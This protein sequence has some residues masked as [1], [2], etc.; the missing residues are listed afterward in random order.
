MKTLLRIGLLISI[1]ALSV[2]AFKTIF[3]V[4]EDRD[5]AIFSLMTQAL[6]KAHYQAPV[7]DDDFSAKVM[8]EYID[9]LDYSKRFLLQSDIDMLN[10]YRYLIDD[11]IR[12][13]D[14]QV[15]KMG[16]SIIKKRQKEAE[17]YFN[18][19]ISAGF[20]FSVDESVD[21]NPDS[22]S[23]AASEA[24]LKERWRK[25]T[26]LAVLERLYDMMKIQEKAI[27]DNDTSFKQKTYDEMLETATSRVRENY[28]E[29]LKRINSIKDDDWTAMFFNA[30]VAVCDPHSEYMPPED[31]ESFDIAMSG[32]FEGIGATLQSRNGQTKVADIIPGS[33]SWR[34][35]ELEVGDI[36][37]MVGQGDDEPVDIGN[38]ALSDAVKLIRGKK[39]STVKLTVKKVDNTVKVIPIVRDVVIIE[40][41]YAKSSMLTSAN[42]DSK[43]G[44]IYLPKFYADF[45]DR[46]GR[47]CSKDVKTEVEK[48]KADGVSG[49]I[50]D[51]RNNG[52]GSLGD[53]VE[54]SGL[55]VGKSPAV[56]VRKNTGE[57]SSHLPKDMKKIYDGP[58]VVM[59]NNYSASASE[60]LAAALQDHDR[61]IIMGSQST[62]GKGTVQAIYDFDNLIMG[63][64]GIK[65]LGAIKLTIQKFYRINGGT[66]Q[67]QGVIPDIVVPDSYQYMELG[68]KEMHNALPFDNIAKAQYSVCKNSYN[69]RK[70]VAASQ[71]RIKAN[72]VFEQIDQNAKRLK[73][74]NDESLVTL[75][76][77][78]YRQRQELLEKESEQYNKIG[79]D[80]TGVK[81]GFVSSDRTAAQ[82]DTIKTKKFTKWFDEL[83]KD[84]YIMEATNVI[85]DMVK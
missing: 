2:M 59:V 48:L 75:N 73:R 19:V 57:I 11:H 46:Q 29:W 80:K 52:G 18:E 84:I 5:R 15:C 22:L 9:K 36:I 6:E 20:D 78:K 25:L 60:I 70:V 62:F 64:Q 1:V 43:I 50:I 27:K 45:N 39:G 74:R 38:M 63:N 7:F 28:E 54:M 26:K 58:L 67:L 30:L 53:V 77:D 24:E 35:G 51:L 10:K 56:Q 83:E 21:A 16:T 61:A 72:P 44:Y 79:K 31:K 33:A 23:Y 34:Q 71:K 3:S 47:F 12:Q 8:D 32:K 40:E 76:L 68:E 49:I 65:P 37:M 17:A 4:G 66:T 41:T 42:G 14:L 85:G 81:A 55:F 13:V 69:K 82:G